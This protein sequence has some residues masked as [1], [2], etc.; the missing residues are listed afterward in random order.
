MQPMHLLTEQ[1]INKGHFIEYLQIVNAFAYPD[2]LYGH[3]KLIGNT[4]DYSATGG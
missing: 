2:V 3:F 4:D 1:R